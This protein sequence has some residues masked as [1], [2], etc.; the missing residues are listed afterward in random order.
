VLYTPG[1]LGGDSTYNDGEHIFLYK[2][3]FG[4]NTIYKDKPLLHIFSP[5]TD[6]FYDMGKERSGDCFLIK[7]GNKIHSNFIEGYYLDND[8]RNAINIDEFLLETF[9]KYNRFISY[10]TF[11]YYSVI[12]AMC[13]CTSIVMTNTQISKDIFYSEFYKYGIAYGIEDEIH[14]VST[15]NLVKP[16]MEAKLNES[17]E[18]V[19]LFLNYCEINFY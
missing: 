19:K 3:E 9:N 5:K 2:T 14:S 16:H 13:G 12:A 18:T 11:T 1:I 17:L 8:I 15:K 6:V 7:K 10:D 4:L